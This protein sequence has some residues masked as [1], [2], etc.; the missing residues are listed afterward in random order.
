[1]KRPPL[2][3]KKIHALIIRL[4]PKDSE[5]YNNAERLK[6][7]EAPVVVLFCVCPA[8][9]LAVCVPPNAKKRNKVVPTNSPTTAT[10]S[11]PY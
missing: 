1:L 4:N 11:V 9:M 10:T 5:M 7:V 8:P 6:P 3:R 2:I